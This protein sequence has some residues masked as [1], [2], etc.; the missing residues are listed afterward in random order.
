MKNKILRVLSVMLTVCLFTACGG[1]DG[2]NEKGRQVP[3]FL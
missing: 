1:G 2:S 3:T